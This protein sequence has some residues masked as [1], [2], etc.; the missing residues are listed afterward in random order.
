M[1][2]NGGYVLLG[3]S[4]TI[5]SVGWF[6]GL[7]FLCAEPQRRRI[8]KQRA[9]CSQKAQRPSAFINRSPGQVTRGEVAERPGFLG[10]TAPTNEDFGC[11]SFVLS[12]KRVY[13][14]AGRQLSWE[15]SSLSISSCSG[16]VSRKNANADSSNSNCRCPLRH[17]PLK[18]FTKTVPRKSGPRKRKFETIDW[19]QLKQPAKSNL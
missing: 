6:S 14:H 2:F 8:W 11:L 17:G 9:S 18:W 13:D 10:W 7:P 12:R 15:N 19:A 4:P 16:G 3:V 5:T 1:D